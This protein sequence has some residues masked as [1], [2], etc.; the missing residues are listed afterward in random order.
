MKRT[1]TRILFFG[2]V[3]ML[4]IAPGPA[5]SQAISFDVET[6]SDNLHIL[7]T[8]AFPDGR[9]GVLACNDYAV[10]VYLRIY[11]SSGVQTNNY[12]ITNRFNWCIPP[13]TWLR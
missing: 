10:N 11:N 1:I 2:L 4:F 13:M 6:T 12:D 8:I 3:G 7:K 5:H 9:L